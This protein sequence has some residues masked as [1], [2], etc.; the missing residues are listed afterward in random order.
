[1]KVHISAMSELGEKLKVAE[2]AVSEEKL[3]VDK[4]EVDVKETITEAF[5]ELLQELE[6]EKEHSLAKLSTVMDQ[7]RIVLNAQKQTFQIARSEVEELEQLSTAVTTLSNQQLI[8]TEIETRALFEMIEM[9]SFTPLESADVGGITPMSRDPIQKVCRSSSLYYMANVS[10]TQLVGDG[11]KSALTNK[12]V[13]FGVKLYTA[14]GDACV[15]P[16][17][18]AVELKSLRNGLIT[19]ADVTVD[20]DQPSRYR[21]SYRVETG[22]R[23]ELSVRVNGQHIPNSPLSL[24]IRKPPHQIWVRCVE[25][26]TLHQPTGLAIIGDMLYIS[27]FGANRLLI[28]NSK[29]ESIRSI[30]HLPGPSEITLDPDSNV[31]VCTTSNHKLHKFAPDD[32]LL[33]KVGGKGKGPREFNTPNGSCF[34]GQMLYVCDSE[35]NRIKVYDSDLNLFD[36]VHDKKGK[37]LNFPYDIAVDSQGL[38]YVVDSYNHRINVFDKDWGLQ[39]TIGKKGEGPGELQHPN[40]IHIDEDDQIFVTD[41]TNNR[42]SVFSTSGKFLATF[43]ERYLSHPEGLTVDQD[44]FVYV[45]HS[46]KNVLVFC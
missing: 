9:L 41:Y 32:T 6:K 39:R 3:R 29:L 18:V 13:H 1:M 28:F 17:E 24:R 4:Q 42:I 26:S 38:F 22:G 37:R 21:V 30:E 23:Y 46:R 12:D 10:K 16:Q 7:K 35:N 2:K 40:C 20:S 11:I 15:M 45:S 19:N 14:S 31:Y 33:A 36:T 27:E 34:Y 5:E 44:G 25:I 43:G 8:K